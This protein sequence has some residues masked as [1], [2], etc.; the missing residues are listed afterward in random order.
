MSNLYRAQSIWKR[1]S[2]RQSIRY[3]CFENIA[4]GRFCVLAAD[5]FRLPLDPV[6]QF[7]QD[8]NIIELLAEDDL[9]AC[10]WFGT[11]AEAIAQHDADFENFW[12]P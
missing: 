2:S 9:S 6:V 5:F 1:V 8:R 11:I 3:A 4:D 7:H 10:S 12:H